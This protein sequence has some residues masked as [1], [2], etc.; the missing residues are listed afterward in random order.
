MKRRSLLFASLLLAGAAGAQEFPSKPLRL[1]TPFAPGA[2]TDK[3][4][5]IVADGMAKSLGKPVIVDNRTGAGGNLAAEATASAAPDGHT[6]ML[7][8]AG[9]VTMN[10]Q[11]YKKLPVGPHKGRT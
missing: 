7:V 8:S 2:S 10:P 4:A 1:I 11:I 9:I 6:L 3:L 5:R